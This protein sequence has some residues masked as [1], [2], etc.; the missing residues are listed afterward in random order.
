[1]LQYDGVVGIVALDG[2]GP[3]ARGRTRF[4]VRPFVRHVKDDAIAAGGTRRAAVELV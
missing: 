4:R 1:M 3:L 2:T